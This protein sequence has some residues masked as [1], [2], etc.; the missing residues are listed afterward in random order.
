MDQ[1]RALERLDLGH[2]GPGASLEARTRDV[3]L[4]SLYAAGVRFGDVAGLRC[5]DVTPDPDA[6]GTLRL[7]YRMGKTKKRVAVPL[8]PQA[9]AIARA[10]STD[11]SGE[12]KPP[13]AF[14]FGMLDVALDLDTD[15]TAQ[16][17]G[18]ARRWL[19]C[20]GPSAARPCG[21][22]VGTVHLP[23]GA[24]RFACRACHRLTY[25]SRQESRKWDSLYRR[26]AESTGATPGDVR[27]LLAA[28]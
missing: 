1:L 11:A 3:F 28:P 12:P 13:G 22:R 6:E 19:L 27:R 20:P 17:F 2:G 21:R 10:Y 23:A 15:G 4:F 16:W 8:I 26:L 25:R 7:S 14:L 24:T 18:G 5:G 9:A